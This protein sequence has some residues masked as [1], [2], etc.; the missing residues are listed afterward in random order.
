M[1]EF[2]SRMYDMRMKGVGTNMKRAVIRVLPTNRSTYVCSRSLSPVPPPLTFFHPS[3]SPSSAHLPQV[4]RQPRHPTAGRRGYT[5]GERQSSPP[6]SPH[7]R[8][9]R[10]RH[11]R[12]LYGTWSARCTSQRNCGRAGGKH[13]EP[14]EP[15]ECTE[16]GGVAAGGA[17]GYSGHGPSDPAGRAAKRDAPPGE[18]R[19]RVLAMS[20]TSQSV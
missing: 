11:C 13:A 7:R 1:I 3:L 14:A 8:V 16:S 10:N 2:V 20:F 5:N 17:G 19:P 15:A 6:H 9:Y 12:M 18:R 4:R